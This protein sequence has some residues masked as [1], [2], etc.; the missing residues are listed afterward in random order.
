MRGR[1]REKERERH[2]I[3]S[4][5]PTPSGISPSSEVEWK[6][7]SITI[8]P[9]FPNRPRANNKNKKVKKGNIIELENHSPRKKLFEVKMRGMPRK[10]G[11]QKRQKNLFFFVAKTTK[12]LRAKIWKN[13]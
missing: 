5:L 3:C 11:A 7:K 1:D 9:I 6:E 8:P 10:K 12:K 2:A 4:L 13:E